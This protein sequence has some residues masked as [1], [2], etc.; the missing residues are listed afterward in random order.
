[1]KADRRAVD[2]DQIRQLANEA[3]DV[4]H[5]CRHFPLKKIIG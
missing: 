5:W 2:V 1:M 3:L 4:P